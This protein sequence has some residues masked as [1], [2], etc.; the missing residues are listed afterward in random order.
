MSSVYSVMYGFSFGIIAQ[1]KMQWAHSEHLGWIINNQGGLGERIRDEF[2]Y[3][4]F[5]LDFA[6]ASP[7]DH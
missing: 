2:F 5:F 6:P 3:N 1:L 7:A 4:I